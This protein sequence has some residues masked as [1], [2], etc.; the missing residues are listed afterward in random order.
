MF[1]IDSAHSADDGKSR[2]YWLHNLH[3]K[4]IH[5]RVGAL[6]GDLKERLSIT[7][8]SDTGHWSRLITVFIYNNI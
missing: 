8:V 6:Q 2:P 1:D 5:K 4:R 3:L 7:T